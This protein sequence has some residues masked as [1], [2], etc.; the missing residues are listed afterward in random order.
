M[1]KPKAL[2]PDQLNSIVNSNK[3]SSAV[4]TDAEM[5]KHEPA[6]TPVELK[7]ENAELRAMIQQMLER[8]G[9]VQEI[10]IESLVD[11]KDSPNRLKNDPAYVE[12]LEH[13]VRSIQDGGLLTPIV[14]KTD[15][16][17]PN[18]FE[19]LEGHTRTLAFKQLGR[20]SI[21]ATVVSAD[22]MEAYI[23]FIQGDQHL[24]KSM[25]EWGASFEAGL[26]LGFTHD[27]IAA[28][29]TGRS[30]KGAQ[31]A[32][33]NGLTLI[34][35]FPVESH[36][37]F[38]APRDIKFSKYYVRA[39]TPGHHI[40]YDRKPEHWSQEQFEATNQAFEQSRPLVTA[41]L[42]VM[43]RAGVSDKLKQ[44]H[45]D[46]TLW[47]KGVEDSLRDEV[48]AYRQASGEETSLDDNAKALWKRLK[49]VDS[50][51]PTRNETNRPN[52]RLPDGAEASFT[53]KMVPGQ[54]ELAQSISAPA[55]ANPDTKKQAQGL[56][57]YISTQMQR[58]SDEY[59]KTLEDD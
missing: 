55:K 18:K 51:L 6:K 31:Q 19:I 52:V 53:V 23:R 17:D 34:R 28:Q 58:L 5:H 42:Q 33:T 24:P 22:P 20:D 3:G 57:A 7:L 59:Q 56:L 37:F 54:D 9:R 43:C 45:I 38:A 14:V 13:F 1:A 50:T 26:K 2:S 48:L 44:K 25:L 47:F 49:E 39:Q 46:D 40:F 15:Q 11:Y 30:L 32:V 4:V 12:R 35:V 36:K 27:R 16:S 8:D 10:P 21:P 29:L 41:L